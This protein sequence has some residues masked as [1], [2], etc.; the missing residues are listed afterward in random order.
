M[1]EISPDFESGCGNCG[2]MTNSVGMPPQNGKASSC[3]ACM[4]LMSDPMSLRRIAYCR[5]ETASTL[6]DNSFKG[7]LSEIT[8]FL[9]TSPSSVP[10][11]VPAGFPTTPPVPRQD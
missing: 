8:R 10:A 1:L 5:R 6:R 3:A 11:W 7:L 2:S 4:D 9:V